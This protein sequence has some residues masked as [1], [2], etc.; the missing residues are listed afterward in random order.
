[1]QKRVEF[2]RYDDYGNLTQQHKTSDA[3]D[4][5]IWNYN[6]SYPV[7]SV[8]NADSSDI[9]STSFEADDSGNWAIG[10]GAYDST[11]SLTGRRSYNLS[12]TITKSNLNSSATYIVSYWS[13]NGAYIPG[14]VSGY[15][16]TGKTV[17]FNT[18]CWTLYVHKVAGQ[19][20]ITPQRYWPH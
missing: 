14:T 5:Y 8:V 11:R 19:S 17:S 1:M 3:L 20:T 6:Q 7:A 13:Q 10:S 18:P 12:G 15:P 9:A 2:L 4:T 16:V